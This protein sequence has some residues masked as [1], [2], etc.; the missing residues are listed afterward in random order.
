MLISLDAE[1][2]FDIIQH[3]FML[4][5]LERSGIQGT[6]INIIKAIADIK[7]NGE[8]LQA[9]PLK[10]ELRQGC[11]FS[12]YLINIVLEVLARAIRQLKEI[13]GI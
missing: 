4:K 13:K 11:P 1:N 10:S 7:L 3:P 8:K 9:T 6:F 2:A 12:I 5:V